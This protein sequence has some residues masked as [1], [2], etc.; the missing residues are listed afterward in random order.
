MQAIEN[1]SLAEYTI[2]QK[3]SL[4]EK[5]WDSFS[6]DE[7]NYKSPKWHKD[8]LLKREEALQTGEIKISNWQ[9]AKKRIKRNVFNF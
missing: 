9:D 4:M 6:Y 1:I 7:E 8:E 3:I 2:P 5:L